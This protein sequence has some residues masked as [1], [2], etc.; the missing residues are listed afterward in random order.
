[1]SLRFVTKSIHAYLDYPVAIGLITMPFLFGFGTGNPLAFWLS[2]ATGIAAF[3]MTLLTDHE[4]GVVRVQ[5]H[6]SLASPALNSG[7]IWGLA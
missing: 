4:L 3:L 1:M 2:F 5:P 7:T 6:C